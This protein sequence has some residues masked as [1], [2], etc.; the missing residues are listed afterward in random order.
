MRGA[1][2]LG[3][4]PPFETSM[5]EFLCS[6]ACDRCDAQILDQN[7]EVVEKQYKLAFVRLG[8]PGGR[9]PAKLEWVAT[10]HRLCEH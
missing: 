6:Q 2:W 3:A 8:S 10:L 7:S 5:R 9:F 1:P 4:P